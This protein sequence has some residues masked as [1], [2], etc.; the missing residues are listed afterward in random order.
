MQQRYFR[1]AQQSVGIDPVITA[2]RTSRV[3]TRL[4]I[5]GYTVR[6]QDVAGKP[7]SEVVRQVAGQ[8]R[9]SSMLVAKA[10]R[11]ELSRP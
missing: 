11:E 8:H 4:A 3:V 10:L 5:L 2:P 6:A 1:A 9:T 7:L